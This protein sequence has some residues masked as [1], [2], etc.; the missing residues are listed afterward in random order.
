MSKDI[1]NAIEYI[2]SYRKLDEDAHN[3]SPKDSRIYFE[4][5][6]CLKYWDM[7]IQALEQTQWIPVSERLPE[8]NYAVLVWCPERKNNYCAY[9]AEGQWWIFGAY[10]AKVQSEVKAWMPLPKLYREEGTD[11][12]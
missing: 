4:T 8:E 6:I 5:D 10:S 3:M 9:L 7:A 11:G 2:K 1:K 12:R